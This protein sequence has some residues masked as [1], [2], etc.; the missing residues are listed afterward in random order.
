MSLTRRDFTWLLPLLA[1]PGAR[2]Q[3]GQASP[4]PSKVYHAA[5]IPYEGDDKKKGRQFFHGPNRS[6]FNLEMHETILGPGTQTH[7][8]HKH[9]HE[10]IVIVFEGLVETYLEGK[11]EL[12]EAGSVVYFASNQMHSARNAGAAPSRYYV[13]ELRGSEA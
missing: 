9:E 10:E 11:T 6:G 4:L 7:D 12:A 5:R 2:A 1:T 3:Q 13:I 8:P